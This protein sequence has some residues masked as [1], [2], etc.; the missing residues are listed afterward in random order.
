MD[1]FSHALLPYLLG[2]VTNVKKEHITALVLGGIAPD[3]DVFIMW[4]NWVYPTFFLI[5]HR[6]ITHSLF[7]GLL[8]A[9]AVLYLV[10]RKSIVSKVRKYTDF[11]PVFSRRNIL[12]A[13]IGVI[14]H[15]FL[16]SVTTRGVP[17]FYPFDAARYSAEVFFY[18]DI[19]LTI[20]S[21]AIVVY[22]FKRP[23][24]KHT[25]T[26]FL[27]ILLLTFSIMGGIRI[28]EKNDALDFFD[29]EENKAYPTVNPFEWFVLSEGETITTYKF[30]GTNDSSYYNETVERLNVLA[31]GSGLD[32]ALE[33]AGELP[34]V[35]M[36]KWRAHAVAVN[37]TFENG[38]W[39]LE[40]Y[41]PLQ[42]VSMHDAPATLRKGFGRFVGLNV[43]V[44]NGTASVI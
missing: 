2:K 10:S 38:I 23:V 36:F 5:V 31:G 40:Y 25:A 11:N 17:L 30:S 39:V 27:L 16:D 1:L 19:F 41:D 12:F 28:S 9:I 15:L 7:F 33:T 18:T 14:I 13:Y 8:T 32:Y 34:Q 44:E 35:S 4:I 26:S 42:R 21:L 6:G 22:V 37:A 24:Q 3:F 29:G 20:V 43:S